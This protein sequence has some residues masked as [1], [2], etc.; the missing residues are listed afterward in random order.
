MPLKWSKCYV[1][2][3]LM[4]FCVLGIW[5]LGTPLDSGMHV[6]IE[7]GCNPLTYQTDF[8]YLLEFCND[9]LPFSYTIFYNRNWHWASLRGQNSET[10]LKAHATASLFFSQSGAIAHQDMLFL[11]LNSL[12]LQCHWDC[13]LLKT[14]LRD[15]EFVT[16]M[17][18]SKS[19]HYPPQRPYIS[20]KPWILLWFV[21]HSCSK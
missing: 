14:E 5:D 17:G 16:S 19:S 3:T 6:G 2:Y 9:I 8:H 13:N 21:N 1:M 18:H 4:A 11:V 10:L 20:G 15:L 12:C 7:F